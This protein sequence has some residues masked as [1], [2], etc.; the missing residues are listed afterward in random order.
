MLRPG[1][2][3]NSLRDC[4]LQPIIKP[5]KDPSDSDSYRAIAL[6]LILSKVFEWCILIQYEPAFD[7]NVLQFGFKPG[8]STDL[9]TE[10]IKNIVAQYNFN[11]SDV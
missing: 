3:P 2:V 11:D 10:Q 8:L 6:A 9:C 4:V 5:G 7:I 1:Y